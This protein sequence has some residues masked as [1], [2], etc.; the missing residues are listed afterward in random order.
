MREGVCERVHEREQNRIPCDVGYHIAI[1][2]HWFF[3]H[4]SG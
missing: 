4:S 1:L 2:I 3:L